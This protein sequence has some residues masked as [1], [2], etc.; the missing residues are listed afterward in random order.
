MHY[1]NLYHQP[2]LNHQTVVILDEYAMPGFP[3]ESRAFEDYFG[4]S[5]PIL[6]KFSFTPTPGGYFAKKI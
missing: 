2:A 4:S 3:G 1:S 6:K 5:A